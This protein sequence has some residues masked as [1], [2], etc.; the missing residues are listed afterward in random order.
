MLGLLWHIDFMASEMC[1]KVVLIVV[2]KMWFSVC[3]GPVVLF[4]P[5][6]RRVF[7]LLLSVAQLWSVF[8]GQ[9]GDSCVISVGVFGFGQSSRICVI[10]CCFCIS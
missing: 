3:R 4:M 7:V 2:R 6:R 10:A 9:F 8:C 5:R 1:V